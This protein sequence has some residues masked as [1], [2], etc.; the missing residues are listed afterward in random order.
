M[1][2]TDV[3]RKVRKREPQ[4]RSA[5]YEAVESLGRLADVMERRRQQLARQVGLTPQ[6]W[7]T[8]EGITQQGFL[9]SLF[10]RERE[11]S[12]AAVS[13]TLRQL[14]ERELVEVR[15]SVDDARKREYLLTAEGVSVL[16]KLRDAR[17]AALSAVWSDLPPDEISRFARFGGLLADRLAVYADRSEPA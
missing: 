11:S 14:L 12:P 16:E 5:L 1:R 4:D 6:Q 7:R 3:G 9:P 15:P 13:R 10:A 8:L 2:E 17:E